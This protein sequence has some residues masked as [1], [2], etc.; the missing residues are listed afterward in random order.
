[1]SCPPAQG[2]CGFPSEVVVSGEHPAFQGFR[3]SP[4]SLQGKVGV[5]PWG[6]DAQPLEKAGQ[7]SK[8]GLH[9]L[10]VVSWDGEHCVCPLLGALSQMRAHHRSLCAILN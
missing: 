10:L 2:G 9:S 4:S 3:Q 8:Q 1:M 6:E 5:S 7:A